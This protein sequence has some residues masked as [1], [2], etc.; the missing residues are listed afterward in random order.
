M[1]QP[2]LQFATM[3]Q[4]ARQRPDRTLMAG[5]RPSAATTFGSILGLG[6]LAVAVVAIALSFS[7]SAASGIEDA[8]RDH[9]AVALLE[10]RQA[11][12]SLLAAE[13]AAAVVDEIHGAGPMAAVPLRAQRI[14]A[15]ETATD[16]ADAL[17]DRSDSVGSEAKRWLAGITG[18]TDPASVT[19]EFRRLIAYDEALQVA[20]CGGIVPSD[21]HHVESI[22]SLEAAAL[23]PHQAWDYFYI[24]IEIESRRGPGIPPAVNR[25]LQHLGTPER[26]SPDT[27]LPGEGLA[28]QLG[29]MVSL[30]VSQEAI[31]TLLAGEAIAT[32][33][34]IARNASANSGPAVSIDE[35]YAAADSVYRS[36]EELFNN[37]VAASR[38]R[39]SD[40]ITTAE[41][42]Q[43]V[44][45]IVSPLLLVLLVALGLLAYRS[46]RNRERALR[47]EQNLLDARNRFMRM[48]SHELRTPATAISGF[49]EMLGKE[50][51]SLTESEITEF[52]SIIDRQSTHLTLLVDD[53]L[54]LSHLETGRLRLHLGVV[55]LE[56]AV[57]DAVTMVGARYGIDIETTVDPTITLI[58]DPDRL[59]QILRNLVENAAKY[60]RTGVSVSAAIVGSTCEVVVADTG[61]GVP[62]E[63]VDRIFRF[64]DRGNRDGS[65]V[66]GYGMGLAIARHL[67]QAMVGELTYRPHEP[68][69]SEFVL[70]LPLGPPDLTGHKEP[71]AATTINS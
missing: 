35:A 65:Q 18:T 1:E 36:I 70:G 17:T 6:A 30:G 58:A 16:A 62:P 14:T 27:P 9:A 34:R 51:K 28:S 67:A 10:H 29:A 2:W 63:M 46:A 71:L 45:R 40:E 26:L 22:R 47:R 48:V 38:E 57:D 44:T 64:W 68:I 54:T 33:D 20:C 8:E 11:V 5:H 12:T 59:V 50:W 25:F 41:Q 7:A 31:N 66:R 43:L 53:L 13:Q 23:I 49:A 4:M 60:G 42:T 61:A 3:V 55:G 56:Q 37:A 21:E 19:D 69:G 15:V 32:L 24:A 52:L 39:L